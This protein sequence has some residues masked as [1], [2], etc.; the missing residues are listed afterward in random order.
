MSIV[1]KVSVN[2]LFLDK[3]NPRRADQARMALLRLSLQKLGFIMPV[4]AT[5]DGMLLS[6]HQRLTVSHSLGF[7]TAAC[8]RVDVKESDI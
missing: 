3:T 1:K 8:I 7:K 4:Y 5:V 2:K 6:G